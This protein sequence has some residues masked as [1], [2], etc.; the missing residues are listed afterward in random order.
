MMLGQVQVQ[1][2]SQAHVASAITCIELVGEE[3][4]AIDGGKN[5]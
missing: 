3:E 2:H 1:G 5:K 4:A